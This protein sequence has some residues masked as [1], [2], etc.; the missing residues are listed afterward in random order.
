VPP[1]SRVAHTSAGGAYIA[2]CAMCAMT[3]QSSVRGWRIHRALCDVCGPETLGVGNPRP[4]VGTGSEIVQ[5]IEPVMMAL[6]G[7]AGILQPRVAHMPYNG[8]YAP[9]AVTIVPCLLV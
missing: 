7:H 6:A 8:M 5:M 1:L 4:A 2:S 3:M 9:P